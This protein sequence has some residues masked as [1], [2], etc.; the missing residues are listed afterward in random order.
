MYVFF[1][2]E[3][4]AGKRADELHEGTQQ[5]GSV[6]PAQLIKRLHGRQHA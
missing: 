4:H 1:P 3:G 2:H 5:H 6:S